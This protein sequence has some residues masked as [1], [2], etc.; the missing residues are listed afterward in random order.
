[1][2]KRAR[3]HGGR[4]FKGK[5]G[6]IVIGAGIGGLTAAALMAKRGMDVL[7]LEQGDRPGGCCGS[8]DLE[9]FTFD[10][11]SN[12]FFGMGKKARFNFMQNVFDE[13]G[14]TPTFTMLNPSFDVSLPDQTFRAAHEQRTFMRQLSGAFP[15]DA[16][17]IKRLYHDLHEMYD[18]LGNLPR[19]HAMGRWTL[20]KIC[21]L[22]PWFAQKLLTAA[23][24]SL[25]D[26]Y[27]KHLHDE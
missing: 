6:V 9:G 18:V 21:L 7:L 25:D 2:A 11:G 15:Q 16:K 13:L 23:P 4:K 24:K 1:M 22:H 12:L 27:R 17:G 20:M 10:A 8:F 19:Y 26:L 3:A 5:Y 14:V